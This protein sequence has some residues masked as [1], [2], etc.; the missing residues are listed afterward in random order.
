MPTS[1]AKQMFLKVNPDL[2]WVKAMVFL[3]LFLNLQDTEVPA[4]NALFKIL[5]GFLL[6]P[7]ALYGASLLSPLLCAKDGL[8][9]DWLAHPLLSQSHHPFISQSHH[10]VPLPSAFS[11]SPQH[12]ALCQV[13]SQC[14]PLEAFANGARPTEYFTRQSNTL[15]VPSL[16]LHISSCFDMALSALSSPDEVHGPQCLSYTVLPQPSLTDRHVYLCIGPSSLPPP[17]HGTWHNVIK[18]FSF[19]SDLTQ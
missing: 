3:S 11:A 10:T 18:N 15:R 8:T 19:L 6:I 13:S 1:Q 9:Q 16:C 7:V 17:R 5:V 2:F 12:K 4:N 14:L